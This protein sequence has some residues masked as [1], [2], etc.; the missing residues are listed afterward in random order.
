MY[1]ALPGGFQPDHAN[2]QPDA[3]FFYKAHRV[4]L[5]FN[6]LR[7]SAEPVDVTDGTNTYEKDLT[8]NRMQN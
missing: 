1:D 2:L 8:W 7:Y 3:V 5:E 6:W 4:Q